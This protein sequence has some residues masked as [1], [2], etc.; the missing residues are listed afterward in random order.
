VVAVSLD[1]PAKSVQAVEETP[2][3]MPPKADPVS[4]NKPSPKPTP[5]KTEVAPTKPKQSLDDLLK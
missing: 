2:V 1:L 3:P 5:K 4:S